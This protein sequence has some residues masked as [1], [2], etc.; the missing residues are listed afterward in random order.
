MKLKKSLN[1]VSI[2]LFIHCTATTTYSGCCNNE[3][4]TFCMLIMSCYLSAVAVLLT[5]VSINAAVIS[6]SC[7]KGCY[8]NY[9]PDCGS[10]GRVPSCLW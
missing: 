8:K 2:L 10:D 6:D 1:R 9:L 3:Q 4:E 5:C 7:L